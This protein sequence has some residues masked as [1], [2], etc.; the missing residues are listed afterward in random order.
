MWLSELG[1]FA[2]CWDLKN[3]SITETDIL[4]YDLHEY[5]CYYS[6]DLCISS[7]LLPWPCLPCIMKYSLCM[8]HDLAT[9]NHHDHAW[10]EKLAHKIYKLSMPMSLVRLHSD[11]QE[12]GWRDRFYRM[13]GTYKNYPPWHALLNV[14][15]MTIL[16]KTDCFIL[17]WAGW[18]RRLSAVCNGKPVF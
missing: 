17:I 5:V 11:P 8:I 18:R 9:A 4:W 3:C 16:R 15:F 14:G 10:T 7:P 13:Y 2:M 1:T 6:C 12:H